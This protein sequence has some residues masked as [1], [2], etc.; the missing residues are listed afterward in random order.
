MVLW[1]EDGGEKPTTVKAPGTERPGPSEGPITYQLRLRAEFS[2]SG[3][4]YKIL[5]LMFSRG[6]VQKKHKLTT[7]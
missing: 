7:R 6:V 3:D 5:E 2:V 4:S 1:K